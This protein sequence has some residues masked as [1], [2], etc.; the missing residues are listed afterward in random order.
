MLVTG[1]SCTLLRMFRVAPD[2]KLP[3]PGTSERHGWSYL[4]PLAVP[5]GHRKRLVHLHV[6]RSLPMC[7]WNPRDTGWGGGGR[8]RRLLNF[9]RLSARSRTDLGLRANAGVETRAGRLDCH[10]SRGEEACLMLGPHQAP[11]DDT[12]SCIWRPMHWSSLPASQ[13]WVTCSGFPS[14]SLTPPPITLVPS[15]PVPC[16]LFPP[17]FWHTHFRSPPPRTCARSLE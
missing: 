5:T 7:T 11:C 4:L 10:F 13:L 16:P 14:H 17:P 8:E 1:L 15:L 3:C 9:P 2:G 12:T 6:T